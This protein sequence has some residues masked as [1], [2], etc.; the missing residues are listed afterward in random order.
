MAGSCLR[1][2]SAA[3]DERHF[4]KDENRTEWVTGG[5]EA[6]I[7]PE[8]CLTYFLYGALKQSRMSPLSSP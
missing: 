4:T 8:W 3:K 1:I 2:V 7:Q 5:A 6:V